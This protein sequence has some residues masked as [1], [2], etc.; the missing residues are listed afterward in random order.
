MA[1][2]PTG[3]SSSTCSAPTPDGTRTKEDKD[4]YDQALKMQQ[5]AKLP[6]GTLAETYR[7]RAYAC[8]THIFPNLTRQFNA[9][10]AAEF[11]V[12][13]VP[14]ELRTEKTIIKRELKADVSKCDDL[15]AVIERCRLDVFEAQKPGSALKPAF[16][17]LSAMP[18]VTFEYL[19]Q[20]AHVTGLDGVAEHCFVS[21]ERMITRR[22]QQHIA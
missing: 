1:R 17:S 18:N 8:V 21:N 4:F 20:M 3:T 16:S 7:K 14:E 19:A 15:I 6:N 13:M 12:D 22:P 9:F 10:D 5:E 11:L 2:A